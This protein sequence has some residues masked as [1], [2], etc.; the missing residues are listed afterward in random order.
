MAVYL[1]HFDRPYHHAQHYIGYDVNVEAR[2][3]QH[4]RG[5]GSHHRLMQV[6]RAAGIGF[7]VARVWEGGR[8]LE[9]SLKRR[10]STR[11]ICP[12][13]TPPKPPKPPFDKRAHAREWMARRRADRV[14]SGLCATCGK[15][16]IVDYVSC[17]SCRRRHRERVERWLIAKRAKT[18]SGC[19][20]AANSST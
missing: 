17:G 7:E 19:A 18:T 2:V 13:C 14:A 9:R 3:A 8:E 4:R 1:L 11:R 6:I 15:N 20:P 12:I 10:G 16:P 5:D